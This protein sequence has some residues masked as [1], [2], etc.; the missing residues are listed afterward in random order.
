M[1]TDALIMMSLSMLLL[2]GGLIA[3]IV[4]LTKHPDPEEVE[5]TQSAETV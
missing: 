4:H 5:D 2:W 1:Q 3:A